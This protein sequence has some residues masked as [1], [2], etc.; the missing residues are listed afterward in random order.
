MTTNYIPR[1]DEEMGQIFDSARQ[2][3]QA[4]NANRAI[5]MIAAQAIED[6]MP[7]VSGL[8]SGRRLLTLTALIHEMMEEPAIAE[9]IL[10]AADKFREFQKEKES[11]L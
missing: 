2:W 1:P 7:P 10:T 9:T 6:E 4:D 11:A 5:I 8:L 3:A